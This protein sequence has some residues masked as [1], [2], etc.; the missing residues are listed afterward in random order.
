MHVPPAFKRPFILPFL[1]MERPF[2]Q[3][4]EWAFVLPLSSF[5]LYYCL[6]SKCLIGTGV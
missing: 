5:T 6:G 4:K 1:S 3:G 2:Y